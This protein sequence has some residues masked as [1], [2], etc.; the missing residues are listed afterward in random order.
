VTETK[1]QADATTHRAFGV[2]LFNATWTLLDTE[3]RTRGQDDEMLNCA[4]ASRYHWERAGAGAVERCR[5]EWLISRVYS[6]LGRGE[7]AVYHARRCLDHS[8]EDGVGAFDRANAH[9]ARARAHSTV[10]DT[11]TAR[12]QARRARELADAID[13]E[14][15]RRVF[16]GDMSS[17]PAG[18]A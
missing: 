13:D 2:E 10:G 4:H 14:E 17:L 15:D 3:T 7:P 11:E 12:E 9:E 6:V 16:E 18:L 5:G 8:E 1:S